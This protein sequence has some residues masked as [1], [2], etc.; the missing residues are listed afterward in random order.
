[1][2]KNIIIFIYVKHNKRNKINPQKS[3]K[4]QN[5]NKYLQLKLINYIN[6]DDMPALKPAVFY[7][8]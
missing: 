4:S 1:M 2:K 6:N 7:I 5:R 8:S 3:F